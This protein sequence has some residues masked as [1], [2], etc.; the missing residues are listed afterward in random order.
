MES[1]IEIDARRLMDTAAPS[2][3]HY[4]F[5]K[6]ITRDAQL[7]DEGKAFVQAGFSIMMEA[8]CLNAHQHG[9]WEDGERNMGEM[10][11]LMHSEL[12]EA[13]ESYRDNDPTLWHA[14]SGKPE[15]LASEFADVLIRI[16]DTCQTL[17]IPLIKALIEKHAYNQTRPYRHGG[18]KI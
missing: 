14:E 5:H 10:I 17:N 15:G 3:N 13:L 12:S 18:K 11:A 9:W 2:D 7:T 6:F 8:S 4:I 1:K 16:F